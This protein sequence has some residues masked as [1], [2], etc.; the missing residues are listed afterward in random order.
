MKTR[1]GIVM[2]VFEAV[3]SNDEQKTFAALREWLESIAAQGDAPTDGGA[4]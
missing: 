2:A 1:A 3:E 4:R